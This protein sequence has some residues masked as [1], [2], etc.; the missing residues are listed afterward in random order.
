MTLQQFRQATSS[1]LSQAGDLKVDPPQ[2]AD[3]LKSTQPDP[4]K[5]KDLVAEAAISQGGG[6]GTITVEA[7]ATGDLVDGATGKLDAAVQNCPKVTITSPQVGQA[8]V[9]FSRIDV[10][11][12]ADKAAAVQFTTTITPPGRSA[13]TVP[14]LIGAVQDGD[15]LVMLINA[16]ADNPA[17]AQSS[18]AAQPS[19]APPDTAAFTSL[20]QKAYTTEKNALG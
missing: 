4:D 12:I 10:S 7:I 11:K 3:A 19:V 14:A 20:L 8:T 1:R 13:V 9:E 16:V 2:C 15:R 5:I 6:Q 17:A 18:G